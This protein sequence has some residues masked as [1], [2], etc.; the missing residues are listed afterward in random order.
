[1]FVRIPASAANSGH[2]PSV[3]SRHGQPAT[4]QTQTSFFSST[5]RWVYVLLL[6]GILPFLIAHWML[7]KKITV[8]NWPYCTL[9][10]QERNRW[11]MFGAIAGGITVVLLLSAIFLP[12]GKAALVLVPGLVTVVVGLLLVRK[13][14]WQHFCQ[15]ETSPGGEYFTVQDPAPAFAAEVESAGYRVI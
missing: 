11:L 12:S 13:G 3:C 9:C 5:P 6:C 15:V 4:G 1:M 7:Q 8:R 10:S 2:L 14:F